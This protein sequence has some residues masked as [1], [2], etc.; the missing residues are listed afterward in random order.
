MGHFSIGSLT[1]NMKVFIVISIAITT[2]PLGTDE[3]W[4]TWGS[5]TNGTWGTWGSGTNGTWDRSM[6]FGSG[7]NETWGAWGSGTNGTWG[8]WGS[9][10]N[11]TLGNWGSGYMSFEE[12][13]L[14]IQSSW[15]VP[16]IP[17]PGTF[18]LLFA[19]FL[20]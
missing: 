6:T 8:T 3:T 20:R 5:G 19:L 16:E 12:S 10:T 1:V 7:T 17:I 14:D 2:I 15:I 13:S 18:F 11:G 9:G 4:G